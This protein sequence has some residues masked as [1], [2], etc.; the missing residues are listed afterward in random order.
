[1]LTDN[2]YVDERIEL[3]ALIFRLS[4]NP[5]VSHKLTKY[6]RNLNRKFACLKEHSVVEYTKRYL[7]CDYLREKHDF[8]FDAVVTLA[9]HLKKDNGGFS[10]VDN[11]DY[12]IDDEIIVR[13]TEENAHQFVEHLNQFYSESNFTNFFNAYTKYFEKQSSTLYNNVISEIDTDWFLKYL[14]DDDY[15]RVALIPFTSSGACGI[16]L[17]GE[18]LN[19]RIVTAA[20]PV[21]PVNTMTYLLLRKNMIKVAIHEFCH[22]F[23]NI[24]ADIWYNEDNS[25]RKLCDES[26]DEK[27]LSNYATGNIMAREYVTRAYTI[28]YFAQHGNKNDI[29]A[30]MINTD[31]DQGFIYIE[32]VYEMI[33]KE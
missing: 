18:N 28:L 31:R 14:S 27:K 17:Y 7:K 20:L 15:L 21:F 11:I 30:R 19:N 22:S 6:Q 26:I 16:T 25:F 1:M 32:Q 3:T 9:L 23:G 5:Q 29:V 24:K 8:G 2:N 33:A 4:G 13:W 12:L 10:L